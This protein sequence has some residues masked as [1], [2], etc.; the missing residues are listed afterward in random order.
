MPTEARL[1]R[2]TTNRRTTHV[3]ALSAED[4]ALIFVGMLMPLTVPAAPEPTHVPAD[5][6]GVVDKYPTAEYLMWRG[7]YGALLDHRNRSWLGEQIIE[8][9]EAG[10]DEHVPDPWGPEACRAGAC[11]HPLADGG[12]L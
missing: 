9:A 12:H 7:V 3:M 1:F 11:G 10:A 5:D 2:L 4:A 8:V 6:G